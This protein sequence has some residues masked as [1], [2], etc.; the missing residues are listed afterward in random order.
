[1]RKIT[2]VFVAGLMLSAEA[3][4]PREVHLDIATAQS[5]E[6]LVA[7]IEHLISGLKVKEVPLDGGGVRL[8]FTQANNLFGRPPMMYWSIIP[9]GSE[10]HLAVAY[11]HPMSESTAAKDIRIVGRKCFPYELEA[12]G[13]GR[14]S[15]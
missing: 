11:R 5:K 9:K 10:N 3:P 14:L 15:Q 6:I 7:C 4:P 13:G 8:E 12:A 2:L 1:M